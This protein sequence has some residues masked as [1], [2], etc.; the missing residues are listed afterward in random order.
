MTKIKCERKVLLEVCKICGSLADE[1]RV[2][3]EDPY[4]VVEVVDPAHVALAVTKMDYIY[5]GKI[6]NDYELLE[7]DLIKPIL[8][9]IK[10]DSVVL[11]W[12]RGDDPVNPV[13]ISGQDEDALSY[14]ATLK[15]DDPTGML[16]MKLPDLGLPFKVDASPEKMLRFFKIASNLSDNVVIYNEKDDRFTYLSVDGDNGKAKMCI[17]GPEKVVNKKAVGRSAFPLDYFDNTLRTVEECKK[18]TLHFGEDYPINIFGE[19]ESHVKFQFMI[20]PRIESE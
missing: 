18:V 9:F 8:S 4:M 2:A 5:M 13:T 20:S 15:M 17:G 16:K 10:G 14:K 11:E 12:E 3:F 6:D 7:F 19:T 1:G